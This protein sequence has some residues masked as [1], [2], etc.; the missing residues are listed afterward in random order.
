MHLDIIT[1]GEMHVTR[2]FFEDLSRQRVQYKHNHTKDGTIQQGLLP[3]RVC[4][5][6]LWDIS[7]PAEHLDKMLTTL[8]NDGKGDGEG[9]PITP[10]FKMNLALAQMRRLMRLNKIPDVWETKLSLCPIP[11]HME[12]I[13]IGMKDDEF[14]ERGIEQ[15]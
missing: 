9:S 15:I 11:K 3:I 13:A 14:N 2:D 10:S 8:F 6:Q 5:I 12:M 4:P 7:F 1:R